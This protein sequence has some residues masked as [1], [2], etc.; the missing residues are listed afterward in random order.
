[1]A[2]PKPTKEQVKEA[3][4]KVAEYEKKMK[5]LQEEYA[6]YRKVFR[7]RG[8]NTIDSEWSLRWPLNQYFANDESAQLSRE[9]F[10]EILADNEEL[11]LRYIDSKTYSYETKSYVEDGYRD[12]CFKC[13]LNYPDK[14]FK[15]VD[16]HLNTIQYK[17][18]ATDSWY[19]NDGF[20]FT[21]EEL[22]TIWQ[23]NGNYYLESFRNTVNNFYTLFLV[24]PDRFTYEDKMLLA[25]RIM[26]RSKDTRALEL[27]K[28]P[29]ISQDI[30]DLLESYL[31]MQKLK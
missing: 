13:L 25:K 22:D 9:I 20:K 15:K 17:A 8:K 23:L 30:K 5:Q 19:R 11:A 12:I 10:L 18:Q 7:L 28:H 27:I 31:L 1:M 24:F 6:E 29:N 4:I 14:L 16:T 21:P 26:G 2:K 3:A